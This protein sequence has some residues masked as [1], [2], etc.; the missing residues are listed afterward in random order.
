MRFLALKTKLITG[1]LAMVILVMVASALAVSVVTSRQNKVE[2]F[3]NLERSL[4]W[5][6]GELSET[7]SKLRA[8]ARQMS[9]INDM[10]SKIKYALE[11]KGNNGPVTDTLREVTKDLG[12]IAR[13]VKIWKAAVYNTDGD[14]LSFAVRQ[15][16]GELLLGCLADASEGNPETAILK[17]GAEVES[18]DWKKEA[19]FQDSKIGVK[20]QG[21]VPQ[22]ETVSFEVIDHNLCIVSMVPITWEEYS[23]QGGQ[24][25]QEQKQRGIVV[26]IHELDGAFVEKMSRLTGVKINLFANEALSF[27]DLQD[28]TTL[29]AGKIEPAV[30]DWSI[31]KK[32]VRK[33]EIVL[34][35]GRYFQG[36]LPLYGDSKLVG[37]IAA[38]QSTAV[39]EANTWQMVRLLGLVYLGCLLVILPCA[40][41]FAGSLTR[42]IHKVIET[43]GATAQKVSSASSQ[44]SLSSQNLAAGASQQAASLEE[45]S[46]SLE[47]MSSMIQSNAQ[48][49]K[50]GDELTEQ[51][52][53]VVKKAN[54]SMSLLSASMEEITRAS[55]ETSKIVKTIDDIAFQTNLL[56]LNAAVE[57]ARAGEA[58]AGFAVVADE[59]RNLAMRA[60]QAAGNTA[61]LIENTVKKVSEGNGLVSETA[62]AFADVAVFSRRIGKLTGEIAAA[63]GQQADGVEQVNKAM[64]EMDKVVQ[65]NAA[66]AEESASASLELSSE[67][68]QMKQVVHG[69]ECLVGG[70]AASNG[71]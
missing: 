32:D 46:A 35:G 1:S 20:F 53:R 29:D 51:A 67:A 55:E 58:G 21:K 68:E 71:K 9:T 34:N 38:L 49:A 16:N 3:E 18:Q 40:Y 10:G 43:L 57:A 17:Q 44:V 5:I 69:L 50:E 7:Q 27:G 47:E 36:V 14:L 45:T 62:G 64:S 37:A 24:I 8:D 26:A 65:E 39:S 56:A 61:Q 42:P 2:S 60:A 70:A 12:N 63:S 30:Q 15:R 28:Y 31:E 4:N 25:V 41:F 54:D 52:G 23:R 19:K 6:R 59:V 33:N 13:T 22:E 11:M 66:N 48:S